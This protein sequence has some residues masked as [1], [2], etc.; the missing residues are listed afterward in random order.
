MFSIET[1]YNPYLGINQNVMRLVVSLKVEESVQIE[2]APLSLAIVL[3]HSGSMEGEK[4]RAA[5]NGAARIVEA[6]D[7]QVTLT[8]VTFNG[9]SNVLFGPASCTPDQ[10]QHALQALQRVRANDGTAMSTALYS[11]I[12]AFQAYQD[13]A[14][15]VMFLTDGY[16]GESI[17]VLH[18][19]VD[20][21]VPE[22]ISIHAWG[23]GA[24][25]EPKE[26]RYMAERTHGSADIIPAPQQIGTAF[27]QSFNRLRQTALTDVHLLLWTPVAVAVKQIQQVYPT[28]VP[29]SL[30]LDGSNQRQQLVSLGSLAMG[31]QRELLVDLELAA[32]DPGQRYMV[33]RPAVRY[34]LT[35]SGVQEENAPRERWVAVEWTRDTAL[36]TQIDPHI[37]HYT[38][39]EGLSD[40]IK[41]GNEAL[42]Q[43][44]K[45]A[46]DL[47]LKALEMAQN[48][49]NTQIT[50]I[51]TRIVTRGA[52]GRAQLKAVSS[53]DKTTLEITEGKTSR[54]S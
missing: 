43:G 8:I 16:N 21:C 17:D 28:I 3:D 29:L 24:D 51:L 30:Q 44:D 9:S 54:L 34:T 53:L 14:R 23:V 50:E 33:F 18:R 36:A 47:L 52:D 35:G 45:Q 7:E 19:A 15:I 1:H 2:P 20:Q 27:M 6:L 13:Q 12:R 5:C 48:V 37:A 40:L 49:H 10:K 4:I 31:D 11:V 42:K 25:W 32:H 38:D 41:R 39:E 26:L 22:H 46:A